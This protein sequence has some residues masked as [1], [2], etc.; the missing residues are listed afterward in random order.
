M[1]FLVKVNQEQFVQQEYNFSEE[2]DRA[3]YANF[4]KLMVRKVN[5]DSKYTSVFLNSKEPHFPLLL[6]LLRMHN[7]SDRIMQTSSKLAIMEL[8]N[9]N[10]QEVQEYLANFPFVLFYPLFCMQTQERLR[11]TVEED[12]DT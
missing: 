2:E 10:S 3:Y 4:L 12:Q 11:M 6:Q 7:C 8:S 9:S 5:A 1:Y